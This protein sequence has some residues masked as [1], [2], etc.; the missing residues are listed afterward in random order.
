MVD[1]LMFSRF[2]SLRRKDARGSAE[3]AAEGVV[4]GAPGMLSGTGKRLHVL[5][6]GH[7]G[8]S[9]GAKFLY[10]AVIIGACFAF[11]KTRNG[12]MAAYRSGV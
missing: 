8:L 2:A 7:G 9:W 11:V 3:F 12:Q 10:A 5:G 4:P 6:E 1:W